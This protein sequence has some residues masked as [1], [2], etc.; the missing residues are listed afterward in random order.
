MT[1][2]EKSLKQVQRASSVM[3]YRNIKVAIETSHLNSMGKLLQGPVD[4]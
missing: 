2:T 3:K 1:E 4:Q